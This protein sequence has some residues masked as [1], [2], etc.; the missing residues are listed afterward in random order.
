MIRRTD[1]QPKARQS[2][3]ESLVGLARRNPAEGFVQAL[4]P[5]KARESDLI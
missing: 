4:C 2:Q 1:I 3:A 5:I